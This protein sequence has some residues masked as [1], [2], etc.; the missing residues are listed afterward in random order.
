MFHVY[1]LSM[2]P[3]PQGWPTRGGAVVA[4]DPPIGRRSP[5]PG[6]FDAPTWGGHRG[7]V[8][9]VFDCEPT[10][11]FGKHDVPLVT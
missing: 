5:P 8:V 9:G 1:D 2:H 6:I 11:H 3:P 10:V 4:D 7:I